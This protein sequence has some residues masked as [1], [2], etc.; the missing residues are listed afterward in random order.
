MTSPHEAWPFLGPGWQPA[1]TDVWGEPVCWTSMTSAWGLWPRHPEWL[2]AHPHHIA[3]A[4]SL[5]CFLLSKTPYSCGPL[6][7]F[8]RRVG[9]RGWG[10]GV[11]QLPAP[12]AT[13]A[14]GAPALLR[15]VS[16]SSP[17]GSGLLLANTPL[18]LPQPSLLPAVPGSSLGLPSGLHRLVSLRGP[19][20]SPRLTRPSPSSHTA[21]LGVARPYQDLSYLRCNPEPSMKCSSLPPCLPQPLCS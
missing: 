2:R 20:L 6:P 8:V 19:H 4:M 10:E 16:L 5:G 21:F 15:S 17:R 12:G 11:L 13:S 9:L 3:T 7:S 14:Q 1:F 18:P